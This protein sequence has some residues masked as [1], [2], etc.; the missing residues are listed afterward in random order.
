MG[1]LVTCDQV[2][3][4]EIKTGPGGEKRKYPV[5]TPQGVFQLVQAQSPH[6]PGGFGSVNT[7]HDLVSLACTCPDGQKLDGPSKTCVA[8]PAGHTCH[9]GV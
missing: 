9:G 2:A 6:V 1:G 5:C 8:C 7:I 3:D 4:S